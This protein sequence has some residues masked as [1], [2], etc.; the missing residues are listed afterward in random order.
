MSP[1]KLNDVIIEKLDS[2]K[3]LG[4][5]LDKHLTFKPH[6]AFISSKIAKNLGILFKIKHYLPRDIRLNL[7]YS[8]IYPYLIY[9]I[10]I[11]GGNYPTRLQPLIILQKRSLRFIL[12]LSYNSHV[13]HFFPTMKI[14]N[15]YQLHIFRILCFMYRY[16]HNLLP[17]TFKNLFTDIHFQYGS[18]YKYCYQLPYCRTNYLKYSVRFFGPQQWNKLPQDIKLLNSYDLF[19]KKT[20]EI[21]LTNSSYFLD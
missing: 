11:W 13:S 2:T 19:K 21:I 15:I 12:N 4:I 18:K 9:G 7:Y 10:N 16:F 14:M 1:I 8:F 5:L 3:F 20:E 17:I 6:I